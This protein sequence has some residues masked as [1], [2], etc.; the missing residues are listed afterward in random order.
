[1]NCEEYRPI[2]DAYVDGE[3]DAARNLE[4]E[5]HFESCTPCSGL[6]DERVLL[7]AAIAQHAPRYAAPAALREQVTAALRAE[8]GERRILSFPDRKRTVIWAIAAIALIGLFLA[9]TLLSRRSQNDLLTKEIIASHVR[10]LMANHLADVVSS[11]HHTVK[12]WFD[13]KIDFAP[14]V[15]DL[16]AEGFPL[17][18]GRLDYFDQHPVAALVYGSDKHFINLFVWPSDSKHSQAS[19]EGKTASNGYNL[20]HWA[21]SGMDYWAVSD[22]NPATLGQFVQLARARGAD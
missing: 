21:G 22:V 20:Q 19:A 4:M 9:A 13:G 1:M 11:D 16:A 6:R 18:G 17:V 12:P 14:P 2:S 10:S 8:T 3:L 7:A 15:V 5:K